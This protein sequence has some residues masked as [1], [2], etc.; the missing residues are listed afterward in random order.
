MASFGTFVWRPWTVA[1][2]GI[3]VAA[4]CTV[5]ELLSFAEA[6]DEPCS[7]GRALIAGCCRTFSSSFKVWNTATVG[8]NQC[9]ALP[10]GP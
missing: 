8:G 6:P 4:T 2:D 9:A 5:A 1:E 7:V 10:A 3:E